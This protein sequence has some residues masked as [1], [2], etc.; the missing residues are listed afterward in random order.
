MK[1]LDALLDRLSTDAPMRSICVGTHYTIACSRHCGLATTLI[2]DRPHA[3]DQVR[4]VANLHLRSARRLAELAR[5]DSLIEASIGVAAI[6]SLLE[7]EEEHAVEINAAEV[8]SRHGA[9]RRVALVGHFPF[10]PKLRATAAEL[11]VIEKHP[12]EGEYP[13][14]AAADLLPQADVV[15]ITG[16]ALV[17]H[18]LDGLLGLCR[19]NVP[20]V[21]LGPST[22]LSPVLFDY[23][24]TII[25]G[26]RVVDEE[27]VRRTIGHGATFQQVQGVR[28]LTLARESFRPAQA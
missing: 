17:N 13:A 2:G 5:S 26:A 28:L 15:G 19:R 11:W 22:P 10:I 20:V 9:G 8:L 12:G 27:A 7:V 6:N 4:D 18:T 25:A 14:A 21:V 3:R 1:I 16:S 24:A 23:G